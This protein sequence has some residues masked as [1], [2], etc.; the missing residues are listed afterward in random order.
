MVCH[1]MLTFCKR[2]ASLE[3]EEFNTLFGKS[4]ANCQ[5]G[6]PSTDYCYAFHRLLLI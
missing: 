3:Q 5:A 4:L 1:V 2:T 6:R